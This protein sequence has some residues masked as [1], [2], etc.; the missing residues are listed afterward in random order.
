MREM[1]EIYK[2][3]QRE[4]TY[5]GIPCVFVRLTWCNLRC[6]WCDTTHAFHGSKKLSIDQV[7]GQVQSCS[8]DLV[9][10]TGGEPLLQKKVFL[11]ME[12]FLKSKIRVMLGTGGSPSIKNVPAKVIKIIDLKCPGSGKENKNYWDN[13]NYLSPKDEI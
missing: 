7:L 6:V 12:T 2:S 11:L 5:M 9:E 4:S 1:T 8:I 10:V 3:V 13:L